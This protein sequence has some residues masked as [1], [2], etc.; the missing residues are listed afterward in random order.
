M[1]RKVC[2]PTTQN[3]LTITFQIFVLVIATLLFWSKNMPVWIVEKISVETCWIYWTITWT[4]KASDQ[5]FCLYQ[6]MQF[7]DFFR[8][9]N[10]AIPVH[11]ISK[12]SPHSFEKGGAEIICWMLL[13]LLHFPLLAQYAHRGHFS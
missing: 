2:H 8:I 4:I 13:F 12:G 10:L 11:N 5:I 7:F 3:H 9:D 1:A 6:R